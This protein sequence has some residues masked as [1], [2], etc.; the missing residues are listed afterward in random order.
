MGWQMPPSDGPGFYKIGDD[1]VQYRVAAHPS[2]PAWA[3]FLREY[4]QEAFDP[5]SH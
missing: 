3:A 4:A 5:I 1:V 2:R